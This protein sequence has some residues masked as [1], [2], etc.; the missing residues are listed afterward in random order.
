MAIRQNPFVP[1]GTV[2]QRARDYC[3]WLGQLTGLPIDLPTEAQWEY[4][5]R[6]RGQNFVFA[7]DTGNLEHGRNVPGSREHM[8]LLNPIIRYNMDL[9]GFSR[10]IPRPVP[11]GLFPPTPMG[12]YDVAHNGLDWVLDWYAVDYYQRS[13]VDNPGGPDTGTEKVLRGGKIWGNSDDRM[14]AY[15]HKSNPEKM[16]LES[17]G[18]T[19][20]YA[21]VWEDT[22]RCV[23]NTPEPLPKP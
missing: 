20:D 1:A 4:A 3:Q 10:T 11:V 6:S 9:P 14:T 8:E 12:L 13:P 19:M 18:K 21:P 16:Y 5:A 17:D 23:V 7:T 2:W 15:R 22:V